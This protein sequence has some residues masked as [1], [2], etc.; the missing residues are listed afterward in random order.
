MVSVRDQV[1]YK[2]RVSNGHASDD[3]SRSIDGFPTSIPI[4]AKAT[5]D[6][7]QMVPL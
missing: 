7:G 1:L 5:R 3:N 4:A 6:K 2:Y